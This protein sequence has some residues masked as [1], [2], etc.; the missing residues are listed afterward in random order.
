MSEGKRDPLGGVLVGAA[1][2]LFAGTVILGE[3]ATRR[4]LPVPAMLAVR[5]GVAAVVLAGVQLAWRRP[6][7]PARGE[8]RRLVVLGLAYALESTLFFLGL[9]RGTAAAVTLLFF[10]YPVIVAVLWALLGHGLPGWLV[11]GSLVAAV[12]GAAIVVASSG[13]LSITASGIAFALAASLTF[14]FYLLGVDAFVRRTSSHVSAMSVSGAASL[15]LGA[16]AVSGGASR[17]PSGA[18]EW[19]PVVGMG[20]LTSGAFLLLFVGV[21]RIGPVRTSVIAAGE[22]VATALL[23]VVFLAQPLRAGVA[24]GGALILA[25]AVAASLARGMPEPE[26]SGPP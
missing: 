2:L 26:A 6:I 19:V 15:A 3:I 1:S 5:F 25:G 11:G 14:S 18:G 12:A 10:T 7:R 8:G 13:G 16:F 24:A 20:I 23:A 21:R 17:W 22:P 4:G 9:G